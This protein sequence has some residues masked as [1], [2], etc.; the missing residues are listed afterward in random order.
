[1]PDIPPARHQHDIITHHRSHVI[2]YIAQ[3]SEDSDSDREEALPFTPYRFM[4]FL[5]KVFTLV[6]ITEYMLIMT[7]CQLVSVP[8][9]CPLQPSVMLETFVLMWII[10]PCV[11]AGLKLIGKYERGTQQARLPSHPLESLL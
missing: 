1:M 11:F 5:Y 10:P 7:G 4:I 9:E 3:D 2:V 8:K 6:G